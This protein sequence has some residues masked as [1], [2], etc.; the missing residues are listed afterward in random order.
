[1]SDI[2]YISRYFAIILTILS[3]RVLVRSGISLC[4]IG[5]QT[6]VAEL[7]NV[8]WRFIVLLLVQDR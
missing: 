7:E 1:M 8:G 4:Q 3:F 2:T 5:S 6:G